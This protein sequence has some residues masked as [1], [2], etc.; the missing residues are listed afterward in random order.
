MATQDPVLYAVCDGEK[1]RFLRFDGQQ[2]RTFQRFGAHS[3]E[4]DAIG[5]VG[6]IKQPRTDPHAQ[7]KERFAREIAQEINQALQQDSA[8]EGL[9]LSAPP[10]VLHD[11]REH[12]SK[13]VAKKLIKSESKDLTNTPDHDLMSHF[14][15]PA[16]GWPQMTP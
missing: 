2:L 4:T 11:I 1:A 7:V 9:V 3:G 14:D 5:E 10:H 8:L 6:S 15:R 13:A 12:L 16:T